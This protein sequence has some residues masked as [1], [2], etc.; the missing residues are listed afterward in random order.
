M[1][2]N[3]IADA[4]REYFYLAIS[5][6]FTV[7]GGAVSDEMKRNLVNVVPAGR[8]SDS[9]TY[10]FLTQG[11]SAVGRDKVGGKAKETD[12]ISVPDEE[13]VMCVG[14][15]V[16]YVKY[17][18]QGMQ[19]IGAG[20]GSAEPGGFRNHIL[21]WAADVWGTSPEDVSRAYAVMK[22]IA[23][24]GIEA[25]PFMVQT[26]YEADLIMKDAIN[27]ALSDAAK[28]V[29]KTPIRTVITIRNK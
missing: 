28:T 13:N 17:I 12:I 4:A 20:V 25:K 23:A 11:H 6:A 26:A 18:D 21:E 15:A 22:H 16:P 9:I 5:E 14:T 10:T 27:K 3:S 7:G 29:F 8:A 1:A 19:P 2:A 24:Y